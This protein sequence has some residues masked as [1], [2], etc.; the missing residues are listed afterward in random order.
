M[1]LPTRT[2]DPLLADTF[3]TQ[4]WPRHN[5]AIKEIIFH[6]Y[7]VSLAFVF[8]SKTWTYGSQETWGKLSFGG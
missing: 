8:C 5:D 1:F 4:Q 2:S 6:I 7:F 3:L